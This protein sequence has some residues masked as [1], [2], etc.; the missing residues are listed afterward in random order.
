MYYI[1]SE[2]EYLDIN[3]KQEY[4]DINSD[5]GRLCDQHEYR[6]VSW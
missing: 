1:N 5:V 2:Q 3:S 6:W 4:F